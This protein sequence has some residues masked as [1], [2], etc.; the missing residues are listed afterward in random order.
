MLVLGHRDF[1]FKQDNTGKQVGDTGAPMGSWRAP[2]EPMTPEAS[3]GPQLAS[4]I[5]ESEQKSQVSP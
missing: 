3:H 5:V 2:G 4:Q 1:F